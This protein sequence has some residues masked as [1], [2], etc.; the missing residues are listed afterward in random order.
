MMAGQSPPPGI[1]APA[2]FDP[3]RFDL[4]GDG[5]IGPDE[6]QGRMRENFAA[7]DANGDGFVDLPEIEARRAARRAAAA[8]GEPA[9]VTRPASLSN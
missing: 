2:S 8:A 3:L 1:A 9:A 7:I 4:N 5:K 6:A